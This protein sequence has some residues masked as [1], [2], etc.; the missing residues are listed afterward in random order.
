MIALLEK[1]CRA[2]CGKE[3]VLALVFP[4]QKQITSG[5]KKRDRASVNGVN[6]A[7]RS[8]R[9][10]VRKI[11]IAE[12]DLMIADMTEETLVQHGY[13]VCGIARTVGNAVAL[14]RLHEPDLI[15][16]DL[17]LA[18]GGLGTQA[19]AQLGPVEGMGILYATGNASQLLLSAADGHASLKKPYRLR[20]LIRS[21]D[22]VAEL[23]ATGEARPPF[24]PGFELLQPSTDHAL[25]DHA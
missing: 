3:Y 1:Y 21:L 20:D 2:P 16:M 12:D 19:A 25:R 4:L 6:Q 11:L 10:P 17:R 15:L 18:D 23:V 13:D 24:P 14:A 7:P 5:N 22:L 8:R 9:L